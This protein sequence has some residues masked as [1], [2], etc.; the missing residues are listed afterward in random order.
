MAQEKFTLS[1]RYEMA[2]SE[3]QQLGSIITRIEERVEIFMKKHEKLDSK[4]ADHVEFCP[5]KKQIIEIGQR[6]AALEAHHKSEGDVEKTVLAQTQRIAAESAKVV[7]EE[8][9][10]SIDGM[11]EEIGEVCSDIEEAKEKYRQLELTINGMLIAAQGHDGRW[12]WVGQFV[13]QTVMSLLWVIV[14]II[15][16]HFGIPAPPTKP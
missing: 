10:K 11:G 7:K 15:L 8:L 5:V 2:Q 14:A 6:V 3:L 13:F 4:L 9:I 16:Y 1:Q 12:K